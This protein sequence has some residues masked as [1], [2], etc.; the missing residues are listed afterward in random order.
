VRIAYLVVSHRNPAQVLRL[1]G[2]LKEGPAAEVVVRH[3]ERRSRL[4]P[5]ELERAGGRALRDGINVEWGHHSHLRMLLG[6]IGRVRTELDPDWLVVISGQDYP[7]RPLAEIEGRLAGADEDAFLGNPWRLQTN[8]PPR[9]PADEFFRRYAYWHT[10]VPSPTP[11]P[12]GRLQRLAYI[13]E[14]PSGGRPLLG[15]RRPRLPFSDASPCWV[16]ADW[17]L[18]GRRAI[19]A[20]LGAARHDA[21]LLRHYRHTFAGSESFLATVLMNERSLSVSGDDRRFVRFAPGA[22]H[23][24]L[25]TSADL[26]QLIDSGAHFARKFDAGVDAAVLDALDERRKAAGPR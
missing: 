20:L 23:P 7:L 13:R 25:L 18:L 17:P 10:S 9:P 5:D 3:D 12:P 16:S 19:E 26:G 2:A 1:V 6:A 22:P 21:R 24:D 4:D 15:I 14:L 11:K 8:S